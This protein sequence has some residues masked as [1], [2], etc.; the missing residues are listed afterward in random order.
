MEGIAR[1]VSGLEEIIEYRSR[2]ALEHPGD[3][4]YA[5][6]VALTRRLIAEI[7]ALKSPLIHEFNTL[8]SYIT[9]D[10]SLGV[11]VS[12][13][14]AA[15]RGHLGFLAFPHNAEAYLKTLI[16]LLRNHVPEP[17]GHQGGGSP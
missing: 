16:G 9:A 8:W 12:R 15:Y 17:T 13:I 14:G 11:D 6:A 10:K 7:K 3:H 4:R 1:V 2:M 5:D